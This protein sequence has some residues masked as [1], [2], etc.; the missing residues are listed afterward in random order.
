M[1]VSRVVIDIET[2][3]VNWEGLE[4]EE[5]EYLLQNARTDEE[6][7]KVRDQLGLFPLTGHIVAIAM[8]NPESGKA[9]VLAEGI[10]GEGAAWAPGEGAEF[11]TGNEAELL[12]RFWDVVKRY[13]Q[14]ITFNGRSFDGPYIMLRSLMLGITATRNLVPNRYRLSEH[15]DLLDVLTLY[16]GIRRYSLDFLCRR[17]G[18]D[19][20]KANMR[21]KDVAE[22]YRAGRMEDIARYCLD[23]VRA[24]K[25]LLD[26]AEQSLGVLVSAS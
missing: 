15:L 18:I 9:L 7:D 2:V 4:P 22:A 23:D 3:P 11:W 10:P 12:E 16:G 1:N 25:R 26:R 19:S 24:T 8:L 14:I 20:P 5:Q 17:L 21:G 13:G 6:Q